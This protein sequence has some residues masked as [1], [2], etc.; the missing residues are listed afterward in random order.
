MRE[1]LSLDPNYEPA[2]HVLG[3]IYRELPR[4]VGGSIPKAITRFKKARQMNP[5]DLVNLL[6]L[7]Q[8]YQDAG[9]N[10]KA[11]K[12]LND[13]LAVKNPADPGEAED[14]RKDIRKVIQEIKTGN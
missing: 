12:V 1:A 4:F 10:A 13:A 6:S 14:N 8:A 11:L 5:N 3:E 2:V 9:E 7:G